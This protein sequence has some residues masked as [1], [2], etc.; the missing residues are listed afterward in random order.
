MARYSEKS[1][2]EKFKIWFLATLIT[3]LT[4][5]V[6]V[7]S[8]VLGGVFKVDKGKNFPSKPETKTELV[9]QKSIA[10]LN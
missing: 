9:E 8:L 7:E 5:A 1:G 10:F 3:L 2:L 4:I 6:V